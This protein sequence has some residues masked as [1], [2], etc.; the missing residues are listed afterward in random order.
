MLVLLCHLRTSDIWTVHLLKHRDKWIL[1]SC[2]QPVPYRCGHNTHA[3][4]CSHKRLLAPGCGICADRVSP[5]LHISI[6]MNGTSQLLHV[7]R[8]HTPSF[9]GLFSFALHTNMIP[10][11]SVTLPPPPFSPAHSLVHQT[12]NKPK[13][14]M[15]LSYNNIHQM[16]L[17]WCSITL[18]E[19]SPSQLGICK[20]P[21][22]TP[23][24]LKLIS[25]WFL[26]FSIRTGTQHSFFLSTLPPSPYRINSIKKRQWMLVNSRIR[27]TNLQS[28]CVQS[29]GATQVFQ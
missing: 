15:F 12:V 6:W 7:L 25:L 16:A 19:D 13:I 29:C 24:R 27:S 26:F 10:L 11:Y 22:I 17:K 28:H 23:S 3:S 1:S 18:S 8:F 2:L 5:A 20:A 14:R 4:S 9:S 21:S